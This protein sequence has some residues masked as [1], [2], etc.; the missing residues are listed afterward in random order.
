MNKW[1]ADGDLLQ[2]V[3]LRLHINET[4]EV[5]QIKKKKILPYKKNPLLVTLHQNQSFL[6]AHN[7]FIHTKFPHFRAWCI[8]SLSAKFPHT[9]CNI[10]FYV[11]PRLCVCVTSF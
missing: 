2:I 9:V 7:V 10:I 11:Q 6:I 5:L 8:T 1:W 3:G 4:L